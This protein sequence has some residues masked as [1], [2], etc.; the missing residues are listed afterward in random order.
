[1]DFVFRK[2]MVEDEFGKQQMEER[3]NTSREGKKTRS[4]MISPL[5]P[6]PTASPYDN[7]TKSA[8][9]EQERIMYIVECLEEREEEVHEFV[10]IPKDTTAIERSDEKAEPEISQG[11]RFAPDCR[12]LGKRCHRFLE[13]L[14]EFV[15]ALDLIAGIA[16]MIYGVILMSVPNPAIEAAIAVVVF[17][18]FLSFIS[19]AGM[20]G[21]SIPDHGRR[22]LAVSV[23][24]RLILSLF[25]AII[26]A[27]SFGKNDGMA[28]YFNEHK[29]VM[30]LNHREIDDMR[31][32]LPVFY[33][34]FTSLMASELVWSYMLFGIRQKLLCKD[35]EN[36]R[37][38]ADEHRSLVS[39]SERGSL[40]AALQGSTEQSVQSSL[41]QPFI[42]DDCRAHVDSGD[43]I[44]PVGD[45][46]Y[47]ID[48]RKPSKSANVSITSQGDST[49]QSTISQPIMIMPMTV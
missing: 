30:F 14:A 23:Y 1:M 7:P 38:A 25:Y 42:M 31:L 33:T 13:F 22:G 4:E 24:G 10:E 6:S 12:K 39:A 20:V 27:C 29:E 5:M 45:T 19:I 21:C 15:Q 47:S 37:I 49:E 40:M 43:Q 32:I 36:R 11:L 26:I 34:T 2:M 8:D 9:D 17:G 35:L 44:R 18:L 16:F 28:A 46:Y 41:T 48:V 3:A